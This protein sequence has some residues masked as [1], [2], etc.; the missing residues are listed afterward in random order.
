MTTKRHIMQSFA[1]CGPQ[2]FPASQ[3]S[4]S[5]CIHVIV[6]TFHR[7][8]PLSNLQQHVLIIS[9]VGLAVFNSEH[10]YFNHSTL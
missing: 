9:H 6:L 7:I 2:E 5:K 8:F 10:T 4:S 3:A 1:T